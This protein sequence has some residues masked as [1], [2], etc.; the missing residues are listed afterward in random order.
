MSIISS[1]LAKKLWKHGILNIV[2]TPREFIIYLLPENGGYS[3]EFINPNYNLTSS[4]IDSP[5][6]EDNIL[7]EEEYNNLI[8]SYITNSNTSQRNLLNRYNY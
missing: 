5:S 1:L 4:E 2:S 3:N 7:I 6:N 8:N